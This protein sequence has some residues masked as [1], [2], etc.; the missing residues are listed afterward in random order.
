VAVGNVVH[1][2]PNSPAALPIRRVELRVGEATSSC[3][4]AG[5]SLLDI[6]EVLSFLFRAGWTA[7]G[8]FANGITGIVHAGLDVEEEYRVQKKIA[9]GTE[10]EL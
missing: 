7:I 5:W 8:E 9:G 6:V 10:I 2:L 1:N 3:T 4:H